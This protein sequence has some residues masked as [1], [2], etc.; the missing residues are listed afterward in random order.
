MHT[1]WV[2]GSKGQLG[3]EISL[4]RDDLKDCRFLFTDIEELDLTDEKAVLNFAKKEK[5]SVIINCA[6]YTAVDK[7]EE[8]QEQAFLLNCFVPAYLS[9]AAEYAGGIMIHISTD[10]VFDGNG[11]RPYREED[12]PGPQSV[13]GT[14]KLAGEK[15]VLK[16][17]NNLLI[18]TSWLYSAHGNNF[19]KTIIRL[20][21]EKDEISVVSDQVGSPTSATDMADALLQISGQLLAGKSGTGGIYHYANEGKC[22]WYEFAQAI[23]ELT[24]SRCKINPIPSSQYPTVVKR[25]AYSVL[26][27]SKIKR[28]FGIQIAN[29]RE[30]LVNTL[31]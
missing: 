25:P 12:S 2:T 10:Y 21:K 27:M 15:E 22:S 20:G 28:V 30:G 6:G 29:W 16:N 7:A 1:I 8:E 3:T 26:D 18:R 17:R 13:Y 14:S 11:S 9:K 31:T 5:P 23:M 19:V 4:H 24:G